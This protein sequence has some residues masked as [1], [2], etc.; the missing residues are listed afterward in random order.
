MSSISNDQ[1][2]TN[3]IHQQTNAT[4]QLS[5]DNDDDDN[6]DDNDDSLEYIVA[7]EDMDS[8]MENEHTSSIDCSLVTIDTATNGPQEGPDDIVYIYGKDSKVRQV[9]FN[10]YKFSATSNKFSDNSISW[11]CCTK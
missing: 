1:V 5:Q 10:N 6:D 7:D 2:T 3:F 11:R 9:V 4:N 8:S